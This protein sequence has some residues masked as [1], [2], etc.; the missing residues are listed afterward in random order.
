MFRTYDWAEA[1]TIDLFDEDF[2]VWTCVECDVAGAW[3]HAQ[4]EDRGGRKPRRFNLLIS[5]DLALR[6][7]LA[8]QSKTLVVI[9]VQLVSSSEINRSGRQMMEPLVRAEM[10]LVGK[11]KGTVYQVESGECYVIG[12]IDPSQAKQDS[13]ELI[14]EPSML[15]EG[16]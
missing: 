1:L 4:I 14:F 2:R 15:L 9:D 8:R 13:G 12:D 6:A 11:K 5:G 10:L 7:L 16:G 3:F